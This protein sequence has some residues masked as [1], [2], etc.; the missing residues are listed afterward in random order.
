MMPG[1]PRA[2]CRSPASPLQRTLPAVAACSGAALLALAAPRAGLTTSPGSFVPLCAPAV[3]RPRCA[4]CPALPPSPAAP[5]DPPAP[6]PPGG[7]CRRAAA[8]ARSISSWGGCQGVGGCG[9]RPCR[10]QLA[11]SPRTHRAPRMFGQFCPACVAPCLSCRPALLSGSRCALARPWF[12]GLR[13]H[14]GL[15]RASS[16]AA[17]VARCRAAPGVAFFAAPGRGPAPRSLSG[18]SGFSGVPRSAFAWWPRPARP[19]RSPRARPRPSSVRSYPH[20]DN[21]SILAKR[22]ILWPSSYPMM[23]LPP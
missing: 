20:V 6:P 23:I 22:A 14:I 7:S 2:P 13:P 5:P 10:S 11:R 9:L 3:A 1:L 16:A 4:L 17:A 8:A 12:C 21:F 18:L 15:R 19:A